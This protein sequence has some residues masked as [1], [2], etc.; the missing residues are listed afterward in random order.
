MKIEILGM[1]C[2][3]CKQLYENARQALKDAG[4][5][6]EVEKVENIEKITDYGVLATPALVVDG[7]VKS[8]GRILSSEE[9]EKLIK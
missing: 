1:G 6:A 5:E 8:E 4:I 7:A 3:R 2:Y 9:I